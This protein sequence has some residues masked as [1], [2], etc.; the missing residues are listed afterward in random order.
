MEERQRK[1]I[2]VTNRKGGVGKST[3][4][5]HIAAGLATLGLRVGI[6]D[7]DSQGNASLML[8]M[9]REN[10]LYRLLVESLGL[11]HAVQEVPKQN[12]ST[13]DHPSR[14]SLYLIASSD[15]TARIPY[16]L[17]PTQV[18][19][20]LE[21]LDDFIGEYELDTIIIDTAPTISVFDGAIYMCVDGFLYVTECEKYSLDGVQQAI[22]QMLSFS[23][24]RERYL[25][26]GSEVVGILPNKLAARTVLHR[27]NIS[28]LGQAFPGMVWEPVT[29][30]IAWASAQNVNELT[31][32]FEATGQ[33]ANDAWQMT[34]RAYEVLQT[35]Q[36][37]TTK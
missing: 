32:T 34:R 22:Q 36:T 35:W 18:F 7:T 5:T 24:S 14:G 1:V 17:D 2:A 30:R 9:E 6:V 19:V 10:S 15:R 27:H 37:K 26:H 20:L 13:P 29:L 28:Q 4:A 11:S 33:A 31:Y 21:T 12:Y 16:E 3:M 23:K 25:G 8:G